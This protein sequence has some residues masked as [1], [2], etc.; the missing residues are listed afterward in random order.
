MIESFS[1]KNTPRVGDLKIRG[2]KT[3]NKCF[4]KTI[5]LDLEQP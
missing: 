1:L 3:L 2:L 4:G 5:E